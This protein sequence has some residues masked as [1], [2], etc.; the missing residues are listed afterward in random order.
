MQQ[1]GILLIL[2]I[3]NTRGCSDVVSGSMLCGT[4]LLRPTPDYLVKSALLSPAIPFNAASGIDRT[5]LTFLS[6]SKSN[7]W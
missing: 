2:S 4:G 6:F 5:S 7:W 3:Y 1:Q